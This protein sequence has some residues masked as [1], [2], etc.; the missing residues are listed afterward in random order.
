MKIALSYPGFHRRGGVERIILECGLFLSKRGHEVT[1][2]ANEWDEEFE[3]INYHKVEMQQKPWFLRPNSYFKN[4]THELSKADFD[5]LNTHGCECPTGGIVWVQSV[6]KAWLYQSE[7]MRSPFSASRIKQRLNPLHPVLLRLEEGLYGQRQYKKLIVTT[8]AVR[9][10]LKTFYNVPNED[11][12]IVPNGFNPLEFNEANRR[13][14]REEKRRELGLKDNDVALLFVA[15]ELSR[16]GYPVLLEALSLLKEPRFKLIVIGRPP[17]EEVKAEAEK[18]GVGNQVLACGST[19]RVSDFHAAAD[20]FVLP[21]QYE[22][23][24]LAILEALG[25]GLPVVTTTVPGAGDA[26]IEGTNGLL[27]RDPHDAK[28]LASHLSQLMDETFREGIAKNAAP[29]VEQ[30]QWPRV[31]ERYE[32]ILREHAR[33]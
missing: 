9:D 6:Q 10:D 1:V 20:V 22:A 4:A 23:F 11:V 18:K 29:S 27:M 33:Q 17:V 15:N 12:E 3:N 24:C 19:N 25:S 14:K 8:A 13:S 26:I 31:L 28:T 21:T 7:Q 32:K 30:Y 5:I 16:K 2:F